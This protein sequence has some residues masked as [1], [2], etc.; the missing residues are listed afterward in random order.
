MT[1]IITNLFI[2][3]HNLNLIFLHFQSGQHPNHHHNHIICPIRSIIIT[4]MLG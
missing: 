2:T 4:L 3:S 1:H